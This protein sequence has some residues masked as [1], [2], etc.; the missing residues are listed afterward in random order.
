MKQPSAQAALRGEPS[1][2]WRA[3]QKRRLRMMLGA[4]ALQAG[5]RVLVD[6]CGLGWYVR[7]LRQFCADV[8]GLD[9]EF[10]RLANSVAA[11]E[12]LVCGRCERLP[13]ADGR[14]DAVIS[15]EVLE[16]VRDDAAAAREIV[17]VLR[18]P[19]ETRGFP[20][21][22]AVIFV[23]NRW[24]PLETHGMNWRGRYRFG[25]V[26]LLGYAPSALRARL[27]P[28]ARAY[29]RSELRALFSGSQAR[30]ISHTVIFGGYDNII[31]RFGRAGEWLRN[32]LQSLEHTPLRWLGLSHLLVV[33]KLAPARALR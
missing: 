33:E 24:Y 13:Y 27:A 8:H 17:R 28:H 29:M 2:L 6:G 11:R 4:G 1:Y 16:H 22:R 18:V 20:G 3:G 14:F 21:G 10:T 26:P 5:S 25:N 12:R 9:I 15:H 30:V 23:P 19:D 7:K 32:G 31:A